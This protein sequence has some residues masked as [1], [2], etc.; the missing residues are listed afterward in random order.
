VAGGKSLIMVNRPE[1]ISHIKQELSWEIYK[2]LDCLKEKICL[3]LEEFLKQEIASRTRLYFIS[4]DYCCI[5][6]ENWY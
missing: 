1:M 4:P 5:A 6:L 2:N 3:F